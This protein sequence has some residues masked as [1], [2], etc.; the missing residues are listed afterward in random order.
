MGP[1]VG[2]RPVEESAIGLPIEPPIVERPVGEAHEARLARAATRQQ[3][4]AHRAG[5]EVRRRPHRRRVTPGD[6]LVAQGRV[7]VVRDSR[8]QPVEVRI[9]EKPV[10]AG[11]HPGERHR[12]QFRQRRPAEPILAH[13]QRF[14]R[15]TEAQRRRQRGI[16]G[17]HARG[18]KALEQRRP[19]VDGPCLVEV[20]IPDAPRRP[21]PRLARL[22]EQGDA[23]AHPD[24]GRLALQSEHRLAGAAVRRVFGDDAVAMQVVDAHRVERL[25]VTFPHPREGQPVQPRIVGD[26][27]DHALPGLL[28]DAPFR[29]AEEADVEVVQPLSLR[30]AHSA[31]GAIGVRQ[32]AF[33]SHRHAGETVVR[34]VAEDDEDGG[35]LLHPR[36]AV[37]F[38]RKLREGQAPGRAGLPAGERVGEEDAGA[39][40]AIV[41]QRRIEALQREPHLQVGDDERRRHDLKAEHALEGRLLHPRARQGAQ[42]GALQVGGD[43]AQH[44]GQIRAGAAA[45]VQ[46]VNVVRRQPGG[47]AQVLLQRQIDPRHHVA[48]HLG[49]RVPH[50]QLLAQV[51]VE[52]FQEG[53]VEVG[54]RLAFV[55][56]GE[57][58]VAVHPFKGRRRPIQH[59]H[60]AQRL[61]P[62]GIR[63]L[64]EQRPQHRRPQMPNRFPPAEGAAGRRGLTAPQHPR[65][66]DAVEERLHQRG[67]KEPQAALALEV[68][69][70]RLLQCGAQRLQGFRV[71]TG[72]HPAEPIAGIGGEQVGQ[73]LRLDDLGPVGQ[74]PSEVFAQTGAHLAGKGFGSAQPKV[75]VLGACRQAEGLQRN[76]RFRHRPDQREL[77]QVGHQHQAIAHRIAAH[78]LAGRKLFQILLWRLD[79]H[80]ATLRR[81]PRARLALLHLPRRVEAEVRM[82]GALVG[83][84][85]DAEHLGLERRAHD[86]QEI[87]ERWIAGSLVRAGPGGPHGRQ[88]LA[89]GCDRRRQLAIRHR[90]RTSPRSRNPPRRPKPRS[91]TWLDGPERDPKAIVQL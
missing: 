91:L 66:E 29:H 17:I 8:L 55:K 69:P 88:V 51:R 70:Q 14:E 42:A 31:G 24:A 38:F 83:R 26:E 16:A 90:Q 21:R 20:S 47:N 53:F 19:T 49:R 48:H 39:L 81:L 15:Q 11:P 59:L 86:I 3:R 5:V 28:H 63:E 1:I 75:E 62:P 87:R 37:A 56:A 32:R 52:G 27:A 85:G 80:G 22:G 73:I 82:A 54:H 33:L 10:A 30:P 9:D 50:P 78:L 57:E 18:V 76:A 60:Q 46:H 84:L 23:G 65:G 12:K 72:L 4:L 71:V 35:V 7:E 67:L 25:Q 68:Q 13:G 41:R 43:A 79:L 45:R 89:V 40:G 64:L 44:F 6:F 61:Q 58:G 74:R 2:A 36:G 77:P 34:R